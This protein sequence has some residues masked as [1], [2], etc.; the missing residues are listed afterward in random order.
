[1]SKTA[2]LNQVFKRLKPFLKWMILGGTLFFLAKA[3][4]DHWQDVAAIRID[5][6]GWLLLGLALLITLIAHIWTGWVWGWI[7]RLFDVSD[8]SQ[9]W[10]I[11]VYLKTNIAKYL[12]GNVWHFYG[13]IW[14]S[15]AAGIPTTTAVLSVVLEPLLMATAALFV[16]LVSNQHANL[17][18]QVLSLGLALA[19]VHPKVLNV[20]TQKLAKAKGKITGAETV[21]APDV[22]IR[23]YPIIPLLGELGF[24]GLRGAGFVVAFSALS[25]VPLDQLPLM[26]S[27]FSFAWLLGLVVPGAPGGLGVFEATM[28]AA[29][30]DDFP[31]AVVL[32]A[33]ALYRLISILAEA[34]GAS[35]AWLYETLIPANQSP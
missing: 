27:T 34:I 15:K 1:M 23:H 32:G 8:I 30:N 10:T 26:F 2:P 24:L 9:G 21:D 17:L 5:P 6:Q 3:V 11:R 7:L 22:K 28:I 18:I 12:P 33:V 20:A 4:K 29:F 25:P 35:V 19:L 16:A 14:E 31:V 13:R